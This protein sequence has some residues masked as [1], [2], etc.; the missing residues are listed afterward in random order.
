MSASRGPGTS[1]M[2]FFPIMKTSWNS[3]QRHYAWV[4]GFQLPWG[5]GA[6]PAETLSVSLVS[7]GTSY[8][9]FPHA[10]SGWLVHRRWV[11]TKGVLR[12]DP[13]VLCLDLNINRT[14][15][16]PSREGKEKEAFPECTFFYEAAFYCPSSSP[17]S[18]FPGKK[19]L[20]SMVLT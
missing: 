20:G 3:S 7:D 19:V 2:S 8:L 4:H 10:E 16:A 9:G 5:R 6:T 12:E 17:S 1:Q 11:R 15:W 18:Y 13:G 14:S